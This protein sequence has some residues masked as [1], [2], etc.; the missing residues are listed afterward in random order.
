MP[1]GGFEPTIAASEGQQGHALG[2]AATSIGIFYNNNNNNN[3]NSNNK[4]YVYSCE[5]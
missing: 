1:P 5:K 2:H 3:N 4:Q